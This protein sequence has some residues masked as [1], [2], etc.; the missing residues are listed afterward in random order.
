MTNVGYATVSIIPS[1]KDFSKKLSRDINGPLASSGRSAG[2]RSGGMFSDGFAKGLAPIAGIAATVL[3]AAAIGSFVK[4][5][6][7][8]ASNLQQSLGGVDAIFGKSAASIHS[9]AKEAQTSVGLSENAYNE[10]ANVIGSQLKNAGASM[11]EVA[12]KT[13]GLIR[14]GSDLAATFGGTT[15]D[16]VS[17]ISSALKGERDPIERYGVSLNQAAVD[18]EAARLGFQKV[19]GALSTQASQAATMSLILKQTTSASGQFSAQTNTLAEQQQILGATFENVKA[20]V[21]TAFLPVITSAVGLLA[22]GLGPALDSITPALGG[23]EHGFDA[24]GSVVA[25]IFAQLALGFRVATGAAVPFQGQMSGF[26]RIGAGVAVMFGVV[27][28]AVKSFWTG[29]TAPGDPSAQLAAPLQ[30]FAAAGAKLSGLLSGIASTVGP[31]FSAIAAAAGPALAS[32]LPPLQAAL[33]VIAGVVAAIA[34]FVVKL[35]IGSIIAAL[36]PAITSLF[37]SFAPLLTVVMQLGPALQF[38]TG[39]VGIAIALFTALFASSGQFRS[40]IALVLQTVVSLVSSIASALVPVFAALVPLFQTVVSAVLPLVSTLASALA[41]IIATL[42]TS[43]LPPVVSLFQSVLASVLPVVT[44]LASALV[45]AV[46]LLSTVI[47]ALLPVVLVVFQTAGSIIQAL[48][49]VVTTVFST[50]AAVIQGVM[51]VVQGVINV[52]LGLITGNWTQVWTGLGQ[53]LSGVW[54]TIVALV[55]GAV[56]ILGAAVRAGLAVIAAVWNGAWAAIGAVLKGAWSLI[57]GAVSAGIGKVVGFFR[58]L[59]DKVLGALGDVGAW[60]A[61]VGRHVVEGLAN[62]IKNAAS[63]V[64]G[65]ARFLAGLLPEWVRKTLDIHS[66]SRVM[67]ALGEFAGAGF[68]KGIRGT[69]SEVQSASTSLADKVTDAFAKLKTEATD[70]QKSYKAAVKAIKSDSK[71]LDLLQDRLAN[72][73][74]KGKTAA[75]QRKSIQNSIAKKK[76]EIRADRKDAKSSKKLAASDTSF[77]KGID[78]KAVLDRIK[79]DN[80]SLSTLSGQRD[81]IAA[82]LKDAQQKL[83]DAIKLRDDFADDVSKSVVAL[84]DITTAFKDALDANGKAADEAKSK[85]EGFQDKIADLQDTV[86]D[87][88]GQVTDLDADGA[89]LGSKRQTILDKIAAQ[90]TISSTSDASKRQ[91][92]LDKI[93]DLKGDLADSDK[94]IADYQKK[95]SDLQAKIT[96]ANADMAKAQDDAAKAAQVPTVDPVGAITANLQAQIG[97]TGQFQQALQQLTAMGLDPTT[98]AQLVAQGVDGGLASATALVQAGQGT[99]QQ[100]AGLQQQLGAAAATLGQQ[101]SVR[102]FQAG[103]DSAQGVVS[104]IQSQLA[105]VTGAIGFIEGDM[106]LALKGLGINTKPLAKQAGADI[107]NGLKEGIDGKTKALESTMGK[108]GKALVKK[109]KK[110]LDIHSP[111]RVFAKIGGFVGMGMANGITDSRPLIEDASGALVPLTPSFDSPTFP[112]SSSSSSSGSAPLIGQVTAY[113]Y[114]AD[115]VADRIATKT[116]RAIRG[117]SIPKVRVA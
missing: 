5:S 71:D 29:L 69:Q 17:A 10:L 90:V 4:D 94:S 115:E 42:I 75:T 6:V 30:G 63:L 113:G 85:V 48:L 106:V 26:M 36:V 33:P 108:L 27:R 98:Y 88:R 7:A 34:G 12:G 51:T 117:V 103:V 50:V 62:G 100:V 72:V 84:G 41:P 40:A 95:R 96:A 16:A 59:K 46:R 57:S 3:G 31:A 52:V 56:A 116:R 38:L 53:I 24:F 91:A 2:Q 58:G 105:N 70:A 45:P 22:R 13:D 49:P 25:P 107:A 87:L 43:L 92:A 15:A 73:N 86:S 60:L 32:I 35:N 111:S 9:W 20:K 83:A 39:P 37:S 11:D 55:Q 77:L 65:A 67:Q 14:V 89:D 1:A 44:T 74:P 97:A 21:G 82:D 99:V 112:T 23:M 102:L 18:A 110:E 66:P 109:I 104:G 19:G 114:T 47:Q 28:D 8:A 76:A 54:A 64:T 61:D 101:T 93:E 81:A 78:Q 68:V 80:A 79:K